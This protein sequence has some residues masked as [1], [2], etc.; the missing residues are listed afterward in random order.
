MDTSFIAEKVV[1]ALKGKNKKLA[2][3]ES[4]TGG[5]IADAIVSVS[6][7]SEVF[8]G[9]I[10][11]YNKSMKERLLGLDE[12]TL[13]IVVSEKCAAAMA[14]AALDIFDADFALAST[15][16]AD[17]SDNKDIPDGTI[18][19]AL[20]TGENTYV[21]KLQLNADRNK[22]RAQAALVALKMLSDFLK[23]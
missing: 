17:K 15:G 6:G 5:L 9:G 18:F 3:A 4:C 10:V 8:L 1:A 23:I 11:A 12:D 14:E 13:G 19:L 2:A 20:A 16:Y 7:A 21:A 22:N